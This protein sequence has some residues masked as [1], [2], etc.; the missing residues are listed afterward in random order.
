MKKLNQLKNPL[1][2]NYL[3]VREGRGSYQGYKKLLIYKDARADMNILDD[4]V[5][6]SNWQRK[7]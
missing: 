1:S 7:H 2:G 6:A 3:E 5:G 4:V